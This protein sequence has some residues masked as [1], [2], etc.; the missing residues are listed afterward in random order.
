MNKDDVE[1]EEKSFSEDPSVWFFDN[2]NIL[3]LD[4]FKS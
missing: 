1:M 3:K 4:N 2:L